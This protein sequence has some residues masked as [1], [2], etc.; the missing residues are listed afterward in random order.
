[1]FSDRAEL[2][3]E[4]VLDEIENHQVH[5]YNQR[6]TEH[7]VDCIY[8]LSES[9]PDL[10]TTSLCNKLLEKMHDNNSQIR[11][12]AVLIF[13]KLVERIGDG[14][15]PLLPNIVQ[16]LSELLDDPDTEVVERTDATILQLR[17]VFGEDILSDR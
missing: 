14:L 12:H 10:F 5:G 17:N 3:Y 1:M 6:C 9:A 13:E 2:V 16:Y 4:A 11:L 15:S 7:L 8:H